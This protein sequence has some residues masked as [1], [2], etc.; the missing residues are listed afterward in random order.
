MRYALFALLTT[1]PL[2][3]MLGA[4]PRTLVRADQDQKEKALMLLLQALVELGKAKTGVPIS[5]DICDAHE[6]LED[7]YK[8]KMLVLANLE[9]ECIVAKMNGGEGI[10]NQIDRTFGQVQ[11]SGHQNAISVD[12]GIITLKH[13]HGYNAIQ[14]KQLMIDGRNLC[15]AL[16]REFSILHEKEFHRHYLYVL[17]NTGQFQRIF[18]PVSAATIGVPYQSALLRMCPAC[19]IL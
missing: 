7:N 8:K 2:L 12:K 11:K 19:A 5:L 6:Y 3:A 13:Y 1:S 17:S 14:L 4:R 15:D 9:G 10:D 16:L 18:P